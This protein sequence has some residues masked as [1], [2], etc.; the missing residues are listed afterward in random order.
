MI[1]VKGVVMHLALLL[2]IFAVFTV[3]N[4]LAKRGK[5]FT[6]RKL[7]PVEAM[8]EA[9]GRSVE[10]GRPVHYTP[11]YNLGG[12]YSAGSNSMLAGLTILGYV[13]RLCARNG[14]ELIVTINPPEAMPIA[15]ENVR[16]GYLLEGKEPPEGVVRWVSTE[17]YAF[18]V[19]VLAIIQET[20]PGANFLIG[21]FASE[22]LQFA[23]AGNYIGAMG[24]AGATGQL[25]MFIA[26]MDYVLIGEELFAAQAYV[27][28]DPIKIASI[29][30]Q[31][32]NRILLI[33]LILS[34]F[35]ASNLGYKVLD[36]LKM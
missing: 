15:E 24:I 19:G 18:A 36:I 35:L 22:A 30:G 8:E 1:F 16:N 28:G 7:V 31:D 29:A 9:V 26:S 20:R 12:M 34:I 33:I 21:A 32:W 11:G 4:L 27:S 6:I 14:A 10:L 3:S 13:A 5:I 25:P 2:S 23:Q 17:Q